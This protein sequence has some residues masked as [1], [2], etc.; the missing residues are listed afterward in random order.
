MQYNQGDVVLLPFSFTD[1]Q[2]FKV[3]P[4]VIV[5]NS[6]VNH[7]SKDVIIVQLTTQ[8]P[9][10]KSLT[11]EPNSL[12]VTIPFKAPHNEHYIY[13]KKVLVIESDLIIKKITSIQDISKMKSIFGEDKICI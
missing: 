9:A 4:G 12:H 8:T 2:G 1:Q 10:N 11:V 7:T 5:S 13:C 6:S 3:R